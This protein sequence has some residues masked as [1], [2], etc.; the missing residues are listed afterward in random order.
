M[1]I[2]DTRSPNYIHSG[3][4]YYF[5]KLQ[6]ES[7]IESIE[8]QLRL[9]RSEFE[10]RFNFAPNH[11]EWERLPADSA[12]V[13]LSN[14]TEKQNELKDLV[15]KNVMIYF[16]P[17]RFEEPAWL[18][19]ENLLAR[20]E[21]SD[22]RHIVGISNRKI[23]HY[24]PLRRNRDWLLD[25]LFDRQAFELQTPSIQV[26]IQGGQQVPLTLF[27]GY[28]GA[29]SKI[30]QAVLEIFRLVMRTDDRLRLGFGP[31]HNRQLEL[32]MDERSW[33]PNMF[34]LSTGETSILNLFLSLL[35]DYDLTGSAF[36]SLAEASFRTGSS[37]H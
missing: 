14:M 30:Y 3:E 20:A 15:N 31:R 7:E 4:Q 24:A 28:A 10:N 29:A 6:F 26:T 35:R 1:C 5:A 37:Q 17:N 21:Y 2:R 16:P 19:Y 13:F 32:M 25:T 34:Q 33:I 9:N 22:L 11:R 27:T 8:W 18:N 12:S 23:I 36:E